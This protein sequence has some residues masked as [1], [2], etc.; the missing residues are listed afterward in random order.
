[1]KSKIKLV[2]KA[3]SAP[4]TFKPA[5]ALRHI[6]KVDPKMAGVIK[7]VGAYSLKKNRGGFDKLVRIVIGQQLS[8]KAADTIY[9]RVCS[10]CDGRTI[11][12][13]KVKH[14]A[15][16]KL[17]DAGMSRAK[18]IAMRD[19]IEKIESKLV[20]VDSLPRLSDK[21]IETQLTQVK[22]MGVWTAQMYLMFVLNRSDV[23]PSNDLGIRTAMTRL[24]GSNGD[25]ADLE[26]IADKWRPYRTVASWYL[27]QSLNLVDESKPTAKKSR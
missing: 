4:A 24:Y 16:G 14:L 11:S 13:E 9:K 20:D 27:W 1:V 8:M 6:S 17:R 21:E 7:K 15:D 26:L 19:L 18:L 12:H 22:G 2:R 25:H 3:S 5:D 10:L 23:F